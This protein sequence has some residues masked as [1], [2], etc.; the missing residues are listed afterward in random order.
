MKNFPPQTTG[1]SGKKHTANHHHGATYLC[2]YHSISQKSSLT[3]KKYS[4]LMMV[5]KKNSILE[6]GGRRLEVKIYVRGIVRG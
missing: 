1:T 5:T 6:I 3:A 2:Y 4:K